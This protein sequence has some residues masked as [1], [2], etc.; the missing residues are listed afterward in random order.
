MMSDHVGRVAAFLAVLMALPVAF[1]LMTIC[2][3]RCRQLQHRWMRGWRSAR[4]PI[5]AILGLSLCVFFKFWS[6]VLPYWHAPFTAAWY[7]HGS[8]GSYLWT[9]M[10]WN[11]LLAVIVDPATR[12]F[13]GESELRHCK[14]CD[15]H[16]T[17]LDHHCAFTAGCIGSHNYKFFCLYLFYSFCGCSYVCWLSWSP[18]RRC[19]SVLSGSSAEYADA[20]GGARACSMI[21]GPDAEENSLAALLPAADLFLIAA[22]C[23]VCAAILGGFHL[24]LALNMQTTLLFHR[25]WKA[26]GAAS[27][28]DLV[29]LRGAR[30][31]GT[32]AQP[33]EVRCDKWFLVCGGRARDTS[34]VGILL[35][36]RAILLPSLPSSSRGGDGLSVE[37]AMKR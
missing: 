7:V 11:Y 12:S 13:C 16:I 27:L 5:A 32:S 24:L 25:E 6:A 34:F 17:H 2:S 9:S 28:Y 8:F 3:Q 18:H 4:A 15:R 33:H 14:Q 35:Q 10:I 29:L 30:R 21:L 22:A 26:R 1:G 19:A 37:A 23:L 31:R 36:L 20:E